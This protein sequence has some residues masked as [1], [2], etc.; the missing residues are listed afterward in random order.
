MNTLTNRHQIVTTFSIF[1]DLSAHLK[2]NKQLSGR[3]PSLT[4]A[5]LATISLI[6]SEYNIGNWKG[7]YKLIKTCYS[8][9]F[10]LPSYKSFVLLMRQ[11][12]KQII[13][14]LEALFQI[15]RKKSGTIKLI[16]STPLP[17]CHNKRIFKH[18][19]MER[20]A[21][22]KK[23][24]MGWFYG[25]KLHAMTDIEGNIL[26]IKFTTAKVDDRQALDQLLEK[27]EQSIIVADGGYVSKKL[28]EKALKNGNKLLACA[29][30]NM[31]KMTTFLDN[32][33][34]NL[35]PR[36]ET[37]FSVLKVRYGLVTSLPR[38]EEGYFAHYIHV[39]FGYVF[40]K[41]LIS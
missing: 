17:V 3:K 15:N 18:K 25:L 21:S 39:I 8:K 13:L 27:L 23:S 10:K 11:S 4:L 14:L 24:T 20:L 31:G 30:K 1:D 26:Y 35:R 7:L 37:L 16:D 6:R 28:E 19:T 22:R 34:L 36:I 2:L 12:A 9:E 29:R 5:E 40:N 32:C 33:L 38:S 41:S